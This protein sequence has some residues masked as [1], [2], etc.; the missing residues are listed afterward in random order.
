MKK[1]LTVVA[2]F[3][4][5]PFLPASCG[6]REV[7]EI[8]EYI[9]S[10]TLE[11][12]I[13]RNAIT[14]RTNDSFP[15]LDE[16]ARTKSIIIIGEQNHYGPVT[17]KTRAKMFLYLKK[18]GVTAL[19]VEGGTFL[20]CYLISNPDYKEITEKWDMRA[21]L[22]GLPEEDEEIKFIEMIKKQE[23]KLF[24]MDI[25]ITRYDIEAARAI[26]EKYS[27]FK[28]DINWKQIINIVGYGLRPYTYELK[29]EREYMDVILKIYNFTEL[30]ISKKGANRDLLAV[31][32]WIENVKSH[33]Y[34]TK[35]K[36]PYKDST[37]AK[38]RA[39]DTQMA[40]NVIWLHDHFP[41]K[42]LVVFCENGHGMKSTFQQ[43]TGSF[44]P[45]WYDHFQFAGDCL[46]NKF[47]NKV[48]SLAFTALNLQVLGG[49]G[50]L[51]KEIAA[52]NSDPPFA[53]IDFRET[54]FDLKYRDR[55]FDSSVNLMAGRAPGRWLN[56]YD[57]IYYIKEEKFDYERW[58]E[59]YEK[60][61][62]ILWR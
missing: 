36:G 53:F 58:A 14:F 48:Y 55:E 27:D 1:E 17:R 59:H 52:M 9:D 18:K 24:G 46:Y 34:Y 7:A 33:F 44:D 40:E 45:L 50:M 38:M 51:E 3:F 54:R 21:F 37:D 22:Y 5:L 28:P 6:N 16:V 26:L 19:A 57:G 49:A 4:L 62:G 8:P 10:L 35:V 42:Q 11:Q 15:F 39:R 30:L 41:A 60:L 56:V 43:N 32:Q 23:I 2:L 31:K 25:W 61:G 12:N 13:A 47:G 29:N 20:A